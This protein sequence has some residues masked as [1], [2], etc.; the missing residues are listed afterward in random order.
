MTLAQ[1]SS[2]LRESQK[3]GTMEWIYFEGGEPFLHYPLMLEG[4][5]LAGEMGFNVGIVT[6]A[7]WAKS[8]EDAMERLRPLADLGVADLS[9]SDDAFH[10]GEREHSP[11]MR[12]MAAADRL[13]IPVS[14]ICIKKPFLEEMPGQGQGRGKPVIGGGALFKGR[15]VEKLTGGLPRRPWQELTQCPYEDLRSPARVHL[16]H[17]GHVQL[18]QGL[19]LGNMWQHP[20]SQLAL[21]YEADSHPIC[22]PLVTGGPAQLAEQYGVEHDDEY[23]DECHFC[24]LVRRAIIDRFPE[25]LAPGQVYG[26]GDEQEHH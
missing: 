18:C 6:N 10:F 19:S 23:I 8:E 2:V 20:L 11:A 9:I 16:D 1:I 17:Y 5:R 24:Y 12:V 15:A 7:F 14:P 21:E 25:F 22:G 4:I 3:T 13:D 26:F